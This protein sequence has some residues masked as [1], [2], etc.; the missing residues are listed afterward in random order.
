MIMKPGLR[1][2]SLTAHVTTSVGWL[3]AVATFLVLAVVG[4]TNEDAQA[5]RAAYLA[6]E[7]IT[8]FAII[9]L[10][11]ASLVTG[12]VVS[13]GTAWGLFRYYW[14]AAKL[15]IT[16]IATILLLVHTQPIGILSDV[17]REGALSTAEVGRLQLQ[18]VGDAGVALLALLV[19]VAL[20]VYK[21]WG[22][23]SYGLRKQP[24]RRKVSIAE[25]PAGL[26]SEVEGRLGATTKTPRWVYIVGAHA[27]GLALLFLV[28]HLAGGGA[29]H[30]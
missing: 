21:P 17:A 3:G 28:F 6:M 10:A 27:I 12:L 11:L 2:V 25:V 22:M 15:L 9:P 20:S 5:V 19:N 14:V 16:I 23:T 30:H 18:I 8:W 13:F 7:L 26:E 24:E 29:G 1:K 4:L